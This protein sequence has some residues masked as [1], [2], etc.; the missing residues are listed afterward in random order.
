MAEGLFSRFQRRYSN[1]FARDYLSYDLRN[2]IYS[3]YKR[4]QGSLKR[5][6]SCTDL[7]DN[8]TKYSYTV[9]SAIKKNF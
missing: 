4:E 3:T 7:V 6:I 5:Q 8:F 2:F 1:G 9:A